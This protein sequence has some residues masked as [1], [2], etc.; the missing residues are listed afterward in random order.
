MNEFTG[1][2]ESRRHDDDREYRRSITEEVTWVLADPDTNTHIPLEECIEYAGIAYDALV[3]RLATPESCDETT[4]IIFD[5]LYRRDSLREHDIRV[6]A[7]IGDAASRRV[8]GFMPTGFI[9]EV[10]QLADAAS[11]EDITFE[12]MMLL[13]DCQFDERSPILTIGEMTIGGEHAAANSRLL[14]ALEF[15]C[16]KMSFTAQGLHEAL[17]ADYYSKFRKFNETSDIE[18]EDFQ[19]ERDLL[20]LFAGSFVDLHRSI[21]SE[22]FKTRLGQ[23][24]AN[25]QHDTDKLQALRNAPTDLAFAIADKRGFLTINGKAAALAM[26]DSALFERIKLSPKELKEAIERKSFFVDYARE[27]AMLTYD[28]LRLMAIGD[29]INTLRDEL[30]EGEFLS[31]E[32]CSAAECMHDAFLL[33]RRVGYPTQLKRDLDNDAFLTSSGTESAMLQHDIDLLELYGHDLSKISE[34]LINKCFITPDGIAEAQ[35]L[36]AL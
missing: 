17:L 32:G 14:E 29:D 18:S 20:Q 3:A 27:A 10:L 15:A 19:V 4:S 2:A 5:Y 30:D 25:V 7:S 35:R 28:Y 12:M 26:H 6:L 24:A 23:I 31:N 21:M 33:A 1:D 9:Q 22:S 16:A 36:L 13:A 11:H 34:A 8:S